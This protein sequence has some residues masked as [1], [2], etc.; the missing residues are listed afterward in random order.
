MNILDPEEM[1]F[2]IIVKV[3]VL[4][5]LSSSFIREGIDLEKRY[6]S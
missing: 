1:E 3:L 4:V 5:S 6:A 2:Y